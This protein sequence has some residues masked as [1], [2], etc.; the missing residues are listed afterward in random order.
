MNILLIGSGGRE[1]AIAKKLCQSPKCTKLYAL[2]GNGGISEIAECINIAATDVESIVQFAVTRSVD[3]AAVIPDDPLALGLTDKLREKDIPC[4]GPSAAAAIIESSKVFSKQLMKKYNIP[5]ANYETFNSC[6]HAIEYAYTQSYPLVIKADGLAL[7]KGVIIAETFEEAE[8]AIKQMMLDKKFGASGERVV[9]EEFLCGE[10]VSV[11]TFTDGKTVVQMPSSMDHKRI[12]DGDVGLNTGGMGA[13]VPNP[14]Y[15]GEMQRRTMEEIIL[16]TIDAMR[17]EGRIFKGC[18][19][20]G[21]MLTKDGPKVIE[22]NCRFGDPETQA[23]LPLLKSDLLEIMLAVENETLENCDVKFEDASSCCLVIASDGYPVKYEKG[24]E[25]SFGHFPG[26]ITV[27]HAGTKKDGEKIL[28]NGGRVLGITSV[29]DKLDDAIKAS[30]EA[31]KQ[32]SFDGMYFR[33]DIGQKA[34]QEK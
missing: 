16:P 3:F 32:I 11:L 2:P 22:Y 12:G 17:S 28:T 14:Y 31:A 20:F 15:T 33:K 23:V 34:L 27:F 30:Y 25:I 7:G 1:H 8:T 10:E 13:I 5:T 26:N 21:L 9:I 24:K 6:S 18:L 19:Y 29:C 4:F